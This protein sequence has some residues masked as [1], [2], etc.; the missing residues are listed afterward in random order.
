MIA[1]E[2]GHK[3]EGQ[4]MDEPKPD[5]RPSLRSIVVTRNPFFCLVLVVS[6]LIVVARYGKIE[7]PPKKRGTSATATIR[8][9]RGCAPCPRSYDA[10]PEID[11]QRTDYPLSLFSGRFRRGAG[12][13]LGCARKK[14][15]TND[16]RADENRQL[17]NGWQLGN[18]RLTIEKLHQRSEL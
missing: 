2:E 15:P 5:S 17:E 6:F 9:Y 10:T 3:R 8:L 1:G 16:T 7:G 14:W 13:T 11:Q 4:G 18:L 12:K